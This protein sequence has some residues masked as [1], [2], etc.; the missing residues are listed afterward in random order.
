MAEA[1][2][3]SDNFD[4]D[5]P[6]PNTFKPPV[7][8]EEMEGPV[9]MENIIMSIGKLSVGVKDVTI[10]ESILVLTLF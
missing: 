1:V 5:A 6:L 2:V 10:E 3:A 7:E 8:K 4:D 9:Y